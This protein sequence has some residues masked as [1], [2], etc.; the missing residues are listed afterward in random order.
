M[1]NIFIDLREYTSV[2]YGRNYSTFDKVYIGHRTLLG[3]NNRYYKNNSFP[4]SLY[5]GLST[6]ELER[7]F[8]LKSNWYD[9]PSAKFKDNL[10]NELIS[11]ELSPILGKSVASLL[12]PARNACLDAL[13]FVKGI[14][15]SNEKAELTVAMGGNYSQS[16]TI[17]LVW[18][19]R[20][21]YFLVA[22]NNINLTIEYSEFGQTHCTDDMKTVFDFILRNSPDCPSIKKIGSK[23]PILDNRFSKLICLRNCKDKLKWI[24]FLC[25]QNNQNSNFTLVEQ[26]NKLTTHGEII[27]IYFKKPYVSSHTPISKTRKLVSVESLMEVEKTN[28][29]IGDG[30]QDLL[31]L[32][33]NFIVEFGV[34]YIS[35][36]IVELVGLL[37]ESVNNRTYQDI[38]ITDTPSIEVIAI[39]QLAI[40][41]NIHLTLL[42]HS[43][44]PI[45][46][47]DSRSFKDAFCYSSSNEI[48]PYALKDPLQSQKEIVF[49]RKYLLTHF[50]TNQFAQKKAV[51]KLFKKVVLKVS[52]LL[53]NKSLKIWVSNQF[54]EF[55]NNFV[56]KKLLLKNKIRVGYV[57]NANIDSFSYLSD[58][59]TEFFMLLKLNQIINQNYLGRAGFFIRA[60]K[61][62]SSKRLCYDFFELWGVPKSKRPSF[63]NSSHSIQDFGQKMDVVLFSYSTSAILELMLEGV[64]CLC[65]RDES[66][67]VFFEYLVFPRHI[68][69]HLTLLEMEDFDF[70]NDERLDE[71]RF[72][73]KEWAKE[74][75][76]VTIQKEEL[77]LQ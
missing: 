1:N 67:K 4:R 49:D 60:K 20:L 5:D 30:N 16:E 45:H 62:F 65:L 59:N 63:D 72:V 25:S 15:A 34:K 29:K 57:Q 50:S 27:E 13:I 18:W 68:V 17:V 53:K 38:Y 43:F 36:T 76:V 75:I 44:T 19:V 37:R 9:N 70:T 41:K 39:H 66:H 61:G 22:N 2:Q 3:S 58:F 26:P 6:E 42:P 52:F 40:E 33:E 28:L 77:K 54:F 51:K 10:S 64:V 35:G 46:E 14:L 71:I 55:S 56:Y 48:V 7:T 8:D 69:P 12:R 21:C 74:Q 73:Q 11:S 32:V 47:Y 31:D 24:D 23:Q